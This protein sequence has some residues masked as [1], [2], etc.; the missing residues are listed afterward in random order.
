MFIVTSQQLEPKIL[1][2]LRGVSG[3]GKSTLARYLVSGDESK[4]FSTDDFFGTTEEEYKLNF[5][6]Q[7]L[8]LYHQMNL[9]RVVDAMKAGITPLAV[10]N[11]NTRAWEPKKYVEAAQEFG[12]RVE[13]KEPESDIWQRTRPLLGTQD[14]SELDEVAEILSQ[15]NQHGVPKKAILNMLKRWQPDITVEDILNS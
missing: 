8:H 13:I 5:D 9:D 1:Y 11:T 12:Y 6:P 2:I 4:I 15:L 7:K 3:S 10:D 14:D